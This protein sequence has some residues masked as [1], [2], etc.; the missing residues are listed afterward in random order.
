MLEDKQKI[1]IQFKR[2]MDVVLT[3]V[4][5]IMAYYI[6]KSLP[7]EYFRA[8][9]SSPDYKI[10]MLMMIIIWFCIFNFFN[11]YSTRNTDKTFVS[12]RNFI[13]IVTIGMLFLIVSMYLFKITDVS[14][15]MMCLFY[16]LNIGILFLS[17]VI[18]RFFEKRFL[19][20]KLNIS[21]A[22]IV[23]SKE[24]AKE[25]INSILE[26][27][28]NDVMILGCI[29][30]NQDDIGKRVKGRIK[31]IDTVSNLENILKKNIVDELIFAMPLSDIEH[32]DRYIN[33]TE[34][35]GISIRI[36]PD[37]Q[38][39]HL[40]KKPGIGNLRFEEFKGTIT[41]SLHTTS[42]NYTLL[43]IKKIIDYLFAI[44]ALII[45]SPILCIIS[46]AIK[47]F[48]SGPI[49]FKQERCGL[50]GRR[51]SLYKFRSMQKDADRLKDEL[52]GINEAD[53]PV[54]KIENDPRIMPVIGKLLRKTYLDELPQLI[55]VLKGEMSL[56]GPRPPIPNE[57][58]KYT[59]WQR[60][61]LSM[62]PGLTCT[63]QISKRRNEVSFQEWMDMDLG[64]IDNWSLMLDFKILL[65]TVRAV[66]T[67][68]GK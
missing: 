59:L 45:L 56:V 67:G 19:L 3:L 37:F 57:V 7:I 21:N 25:I 44:A 68:T 49:L 29:E 15:T 66:L 31:V 52:K 42:T 63:W 65:T 53:G 9:S 58:R 30:V 54:F 33:L 6:R 32:I 46:V 38:V 23:G 27:K 40:M 18:T 8:L 4:A 34:D 14:R 1:I 17:Q 10:I 48:S 24:R 47:V 50:N 11:I 16:I 28:L 22:L 55:N 12:F 13:K 51:F 36:I 43:F 61:R 62:K 2:L 26:H 64:Y 20:N 39:H 41:I 60:R 5:F 35:M